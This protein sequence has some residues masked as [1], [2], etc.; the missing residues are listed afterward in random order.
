MLTPYTSSLQS[1][2]ILK[3]TRTQP[4]PVL[5]VEKNANAT[6]HR[7]AHSRR[8]TR[9]RRS[10]ENGYWLTA[11]ITKCRTGNVYQPTY[12]CAVRASLSRNNDF[13]H[14]LCFRHTRGTECKTNKHSPQHHHSDFHIRRHRAGMHNHVISQQTH[15][16][17]HQPLLHPLHI[18]AAGTKAG[19]YYSS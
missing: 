9:S 18:H 10:M 4:A 1:S 13:C 5:I 8:R 17:W 12:S 3:C 14:P 19:R 11:S 7:P 2:Y 15:S 6:P 16:T